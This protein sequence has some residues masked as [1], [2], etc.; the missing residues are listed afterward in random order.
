MR[1]LKRF[2]RE[3]GSTYR[4]DIVMIDSKRFTLTGELEERKLGREGLVYAGKYL[5][6][7]RRLFEP[8]SLLLQAAAEG[9]GARRVHLDRETAWLFVCGKD[10]FEENIRQ[11]DGGL[12]LG[13]HYLV[14]FDGRCIGYGRYETSAGIRVVRNLFDIGD[15]LRREGSA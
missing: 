10:V 14:L 6:R 4:P 13:R 15:F 8:S 3:V 7:N 5:G 11:V 1:L 12:E 9:E 2:L